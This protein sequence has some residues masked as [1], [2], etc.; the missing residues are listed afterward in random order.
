MAYAAASGRQLWASRYGPGPVN[1]LGQA[2]SVAVSPG[3]RR[4]FVT[5]RIQGR[6][7]SAYDYATVAYGAAADRQL[8]TSRYKNGAAISMAVSPDGTTLYVTGDNFSGYNYESLAYNAATGKLLRASL[9]HGPASNGSACCAAVNP[10]GTTVFVTGWTQASPPCL[11][12][13][14]GSSR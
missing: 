10:A 1:G 4:V 2:Q 11:L 7:T 14:N 13:G 12:A 6:G 5:G 9:Y 8:W 3:G